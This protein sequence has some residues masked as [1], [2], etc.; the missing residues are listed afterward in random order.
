MNLG[1]GGRVF[2]ILIGLNLI[3]I[4]VLWNPGQL[5]LGY[6]SDETSRSFTTSSQ[7]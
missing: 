6:L 7:N 5:A 1:I 3:G 2:A 4:W